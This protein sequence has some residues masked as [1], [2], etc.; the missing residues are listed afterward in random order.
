LGAKVTPEA[1]PGYP[2][3]G[4]FER[5]ARKRFQRGSVVLRGKSW[6]FRWRDDVIENGVL[7]RIGRREV[8]ADRKKYATKKLAWRDSF[9]VRKQQEINSPTYRAMHRSNFQE[10]AER[11]GK[12]VLVNLEPSTQSA[13]RSQVG[14]NKTD[15]NRKSQRRFPTLIQCLGALEVK[16]VT[17]EILQSLVTSYKNQGASPKTIRNLIVTLRMLWATARAWG[18]A[19]H[20]PFPG[21]VLPDTEPEDA[22]FYTEE[23]MRAISM[24]RM[25]PTGRFGG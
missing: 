4:D 14:L 10:F 15:L 22:S 11:W 21:L 12:E 7:R 2:L 23:E 16:D 19:S 9:V 13:A 1:N 25:S 8:F 24:R 18:Y 3:K 6:E 5:M 20:D 17:T